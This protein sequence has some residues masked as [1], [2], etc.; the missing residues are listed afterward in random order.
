MKVTAT[1]TTLL[2]A[3]QRAASAIAKGPKATP[4]ADCVAITTYHAGLTILGAS[5][6]RSI[7]TTCEATVHD[8]GAVAISAAVIASALKAAGGDVVTLTLLDNGKVAIKMDGGS[9]KINALDA[10]DY[11]LPATM[12]GESSSFS[13]VGTDLAECVRRMESNVAPPNDKYGLGGALVEAREG[14]LRLVATDGNRLAWAEC[15]IKGGAQGSPRRLIP[16]EILSLIAAM[17]GPE[18]VTIVLTDRAGEART[19]DTVMRFRLLEADFPDYRQVMPTTFKRVVYCDA[20][21]L[22]AATR[23]VL[24]MATDSA[25]T[26]SVQVGADVLTLSTRAFDTGEATAEV[27][28]D[29]QGEPIRIA[30]NGRYMLDALDAI[31]N[32]RVVLSIGDTLSPVQVTSEGVAGLWIVMPVRLDG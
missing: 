27:G 32:R 13:A 28:A 10:A 1:R 24:P 5:A 21:D 2:A 26:V 11:P 8:P 25:H 9:Y 19:G 15:E 23:R 6:P 18:E 31:G 7:E 30:W 20:A 3:I 14:I 4:I 12:E 16:G 17:C 29:V 22:A